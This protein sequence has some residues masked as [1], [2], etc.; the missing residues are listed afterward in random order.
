MKNLELETPHFR[1]MI[2]K[3]KDWLQ[4]ENYQPMT[5]KAYSQSLHEFFRYL[6]TQGIKN[7]RL[8]EQIHYTR[9]KDYLKVRI[10]NRTKDGGIANMTINAIIKGVN[11]FIKHLNLSSPGF[12]LDIYEKYLP[13]EVGEKQILTPDEV[14]ALYN[15]TF[16]PY[17]YASMEMGQRDRV[18]LGLF[19]GCGVRLNEGRNIDLSD[20]DF[21]NRR[22]LV[23]FGKGLKERYV[24]IASKNLDDIMTYIQQGREWFRYKH[25]SSTAHKYATE[26][27][28][29]KGDE[30][31]LFLSIHGC[32]MKSFQQR[33]DLLC[34]KAGI[35][36]K[37]G[38]HTLRH[39]IA[40][41][42]LLR[43]WELE[44]VSKFLGHASIDSTQIYTHIAAQYE[45]N[46]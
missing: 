20:I 19:Y 31:A 26:K 6:E 17:A 28:I 25:H 42:L 27:P 10:N 2:G 11:C 45:N 23:R 7:I 16:E 44:Q 14:M 1:Y 46:G 30:N 38:T 39:S 40:T 8:L 9:F 24:P 21:P 5:V 18:M 35:D 36:K 37:V 29:R 13:V 33:L 34:Q 22:V 15:A 41:H 12:T 43:G 32:R 4:V 3:N